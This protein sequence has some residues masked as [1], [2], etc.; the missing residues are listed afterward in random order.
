MHTNEPEDIQKKMNLIILEVLKKNS[1]E[2]NK[3]S[4][5][6][7][8]DYIRDDYPVTVDRHTVKRNL[9]R[10]YDCGIGVER[11]VKNES[12]GEQG[13]WLWYFERDITDGE[14]RMLI[15]GLLFSKYIP[16]SECAELIEKLENLCSLNFRTSSHCLPKNR[17]EN[18][19]IFLN[20]EDLMQAMTAKR[21][22]SFNYQRNKIDEKTY[23]LVKYEVLNDDGTMRRYEVSPVEIVIT[24]GHYYLV[25]IFDKGENLY[26]FRLNN[27]CNLDILHS[28]KCRKIQD[29]PMYSKGFKLDAYMKE[30][31]YMLA[32]GKSVRVVFR[33]FSFMIDQ[34]L[35]WFGKDVSFKDDPGAAEDTIKAEVIVNEKAM[36]YWAMQYG[37]FIEVLEPKDLRD[38]IRNTIDVMAKKYV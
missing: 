30:R 10:L 38:E 16:Y 24:N 5:K 8:E 26:H 15:D 37:H 2:N 17:P 14:M 22:V 4:N 27:I 21:K 11:V 3:L 9:K 6:E 18:K 19:M 28:E 34:V 7:I 1:D 12:L 31:P 13:G 23:K 36:L 25:A 20:I 29:I 35:D 33:L 32:S